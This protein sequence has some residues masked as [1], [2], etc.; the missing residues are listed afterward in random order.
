MPNGIDRSFN[1]RSR[2]ATVLPQSLVMAGFL[3]DCSA[4]LPAVISI[5]LSYRAEPAGSRVVWPHDRLPKPAARPTIRSGSATRGNSDA[6]VLRPSR[7]VDLR[8]DFPAA[9]A[10]RP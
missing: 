1:R 10:D 8:A 9:R 5:V 4:A 7:P 3:G 2:S 6:A